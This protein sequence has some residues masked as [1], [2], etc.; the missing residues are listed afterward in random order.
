MRKLLA[1]F[2]FVVVGLGGASAVMANDGDLDT[3]WG[4]TG[5]VTFAPGAQTVASVTKAYGTDKVVVA[6]ITGATGNSI[7]TSFLA[8]YNDDG[9]LDTTCVGSGYNTHRGA[10]DFL[11]SDMEVLADGS[12]VL[13]GQ[14]TSAAPV[15]L[16]IKFDAMCQLDTTFGVAG[17]VDYTERQG[18]ILSTVAL[19]PNGSLVIGGHSAFAPVDGGDSRPFVMKLNADGS[20]DTTFGDSSSGRWVA[21]ANREGYITDLLVH[22]DARVTFAG[23][24]FDA[25]EN[26]MV[27]RLSGVGGVDTSFANSGWYVPEAP[28]A[29]RSQSI[30]RRID[31][32]FVIV[33]TDHPEVGTNLTNLEGSVLCLTPNGQPDTT[34]GAAGRRTFS[35][36]ADDDAFWD[37]DV[38]D[39]N[40]ILI[41]GY[42]KRASTSYTDPS[43][44]VMRLLPSLVVDQ[45][46]GTNGIVVPPLASGVL[47][48]IE[49]DRQGRLL[50]SG[51][52]YTA[53]GGDAKILRLDS[54]NAPVTIPTTAPAPT[55]STIA[56]QLLPATGNDESNM[57]IVGL[58]L[59][60]VG[61]VFRRL[62]PPPAIT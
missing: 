30:A 37:V 17:I 12:V 47:S 48:S 5:I 52:A 51:F 59:V 29:E 57:V 44:V 54:T 1:S 41:V 10:S 24:Q 13:V 46:F 6:G 14:D 62:R 7:D 56:P 53:G 33:G 34:C 9:S 60:L 38:D 4:G 3:S 49:R 40:R 8:R 31:G 27:G 45:S 2:V 18:I 26:Q 61:L 23:V 19:G 32:G 55:T 22:D 43:P 42:A 25:T 58:S 28:N 11:A 39:Q 50:A 21:P 36:D 15:G 16:V 35:I 20:F